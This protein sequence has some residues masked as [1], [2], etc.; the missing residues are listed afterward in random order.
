MANFIT[1]IRVFFVFIAAYLLFQESVIAYIVAFV[2]TV[3]A[4]AFDGLDGYVARK[5]NES[6]KLA[7]IF[8]SGKF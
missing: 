6:S 4:F 5:F 3:V 1:I 2:L 7:I 8:I